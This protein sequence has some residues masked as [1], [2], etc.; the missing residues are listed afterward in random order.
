MNVGDVVRDPEGQGGFVTELYTGGRAGVDALC[1]VVEYRTEQFT[2]ETTLDWLVAD[3]IVVVDI[4]EWDQCPAN[5]V[6]CTVCGGPLDRDSHVGGCKVRTDQQAWGDG[7]RDELARRGADPDEVEADA[8]G[9][10]QDWAEYRES[11][12]P[13]ADFVDALMDNAYGDEGQQLDADDSAAE[14]R[15]GRRALGLDGE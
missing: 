3:L 1:A 14:G 6:L 10:G 7:V 13:V 2:G 11:D 15:L 9:F 8:E 12:R 4:Q 5:E